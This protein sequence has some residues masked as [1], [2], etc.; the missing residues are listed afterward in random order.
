M[1]LLSAGDYQGVKE[2]ILFLNRTAREDGG[3]AHAFTSD[4]EHYYSYTIGGAH[5]LSFIELVHRYYASTLDKETLLKVYPQLKKIISGILT[6]TDDTGMYITRGMGTDNP[7]EFGRTAF[8]YVSLEMGW[9]YNAT[10]YMEKLSRIVGDENMAKKVKER[11]DKVKR[12]FLPLF[13]NIELGYICEAVH[14]VF[15]PER[16]PVDGYKND[17]PLITNIGCMLGLYGEDLISPKIKEIAGFSENNLL[18]SGGI[19]YK[20][21]WEKRGFY[22]WTRIGE[23]WFPC[24]DVYLARLLRKMGRGKSLKKLLELYDL[25]FGW[26]NCVFEGK[27]FQ[28]PNTIPGVWQAFAGSGWY[29]SIVQGIIGLEADLGGLTYVPAD[30]GISVKLEKFSF[31]DTRWDIS[32][33]GMGELVKEFIVDGKSLR[34]TFK[35]PQ[36]FLSPGKHEIKIIRG[37][38]LPYPVLL[39]AVDASIKGVNL[40]DNKRLTV[41]LSGWGYTPIKFFSPTKPV[42]KFNGKEM[43]FVWDEERRIGK[44]EIDLSGKGEI[45]ILI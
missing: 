44:T 19:R 36:G 25:N 1:G 14:P 2:A 40:H 15:E 28:R 38:F 26:A 16:W 42:L 5:N 21:V 7:E 6:L 23:I 22:G 8:G 35:I 32:T 29:Q 30:I 24:H 34:G 39:E 33:E 37:L 3:I 43:D 12:N 13:Y 4:F 20:P 17:T 10:R 27:T 9:W 41:A 45:D 18:T 11:G 31:R